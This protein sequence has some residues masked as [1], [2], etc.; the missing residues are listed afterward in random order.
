M[1]ISTCINYDIPP[2]SPDDTLE[3]VRECFLKLT[4]THLP[5][6]KDGYLAGSISEEDMAGFDLD[7][8]ISDYTYALDMFF[9]GE[10]TNW[11]EV[12][13]VFAKNDANTVPVLDKEGQYLGYYEL[14]EIMGLFRETPFFNEP[15]GVLIVEKGSADYTFSEISQIVESNNGKLLGA[16]ISNGEGDKVQITLKVGNTGLNSIIQSFRR[17][18]YGIVMGNEDDMYLAN[19]KE[20]SDYLKKFLNI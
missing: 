3:K 19:L 20:R 15:G 10:H 8:K 12:L 9:V 5:V 4:N 18:G 2:L 7:K 11:L 6:V 16:F 13:E 14:T 1:E 17:Y